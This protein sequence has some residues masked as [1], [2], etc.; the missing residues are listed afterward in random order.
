M[1]SV[2]VY[3]I[4]FVCLVCLQL[5]CLSHAP[6]RIR[7]FSFGERI[8]QSRATPGPSAS[9]EFLFPLSE[10]GWA[11]IGLSTDRAKEPLTAARCVNFLLFQNQNALSKKET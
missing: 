4:L 5:A 9:L 2:Y 11:N 1:V 6:I 7:G 8:R 10:I 3:V